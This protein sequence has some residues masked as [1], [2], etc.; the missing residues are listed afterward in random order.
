M[1]VLSFKQ[2][3]DVPACGMMVALNMVTTDDMKMTVRTSASWPVHALSTLP[4]KLS[5][6]AAIHGL[7]LRK[8]VLTSAVVRQ[9]LVVG[10]SGAV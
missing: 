6:S 2:G 1:V 9:Y 5:G 3:L 7:S 8:V 4:G 10:R